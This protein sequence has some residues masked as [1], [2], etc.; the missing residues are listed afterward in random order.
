[1]ILRSRVAYL[2]GAWEGA[3]AHPR[4]LPV[5]CPSVCF[6]QNMF[7]LHAAEMEAAIKRHGGRCPW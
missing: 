5:L 4:G 1:M 7:E 6:F 3:S 2:S